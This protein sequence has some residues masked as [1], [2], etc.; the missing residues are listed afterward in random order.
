MVR[1]ARVPCPGG[2]EKMEQSHKASE[3]TLPGSQFMSHMGRLGSRGRGAPKRL[4]PRDT[5][6]SHGKRSLT[7]DCSGA[8]DWAKGLL[9]EA[10]FEGRQGIKITAS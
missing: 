5:L 2:T 1:G 8:L 4:Y 10:D 6:L 3:E 9:S 7:M